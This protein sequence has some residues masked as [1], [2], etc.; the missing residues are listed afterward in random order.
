MMITQV[1]YK[2]IE[3]KPKKKKIKHLKLN[4]KHT[5]IRFPKNTT[6][7]S[8]PPQIPPPPFPPYPPINVMRSD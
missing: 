2:N 5:E 7:I 6:R 8:S 3:G 1:I 4:C